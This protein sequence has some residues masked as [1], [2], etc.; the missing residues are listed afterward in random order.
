MNDKLEPLTPEDWFVGGHGIIGGHK[1]SHGV[2]I[3]DHEPAGNLHLWAPQPAVAD[4]ML[5]ELLKARHKRSDTF[6]VVVIPRLM[7]PRWRRLFHKVSDLHF[8]VPAGTEYWPSHMYEP[9]WIGIILPFV[10]FRPW[11]LKRAPLLVELAR[12]LCEVCKD[13]D[14]AARN[15]LRKLLKLP[16][17]LAKLSPSVASG[18]LHMPREVLR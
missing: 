5:E 6:H 9:L 17:R 3:P 8:V 14:V 11:Q 18:V 1:D 10:P 7:S 2:W 13:H 12:K 16:R 4:A 15:I